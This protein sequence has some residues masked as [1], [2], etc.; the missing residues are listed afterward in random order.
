MLLDNAAKKL[1]YRALKV[2]ESSIQTA[3]ETF[4]KYQENLGKLV[5]IK[6]NSGAFKTSKGSFVRFGKKGSPDFIVFLQNGKTLHLEIKNFS[7]RQQKSQK[8]YQQKI[9]DLGHLYYVAHS[10]EEVKKM[11][12]NI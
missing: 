11:I 7:G 10:V 9:E 8:E 4:L 12:K 6:N 3:I 1:A 5:F 2:S